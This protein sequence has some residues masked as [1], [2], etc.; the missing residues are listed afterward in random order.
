MEIRVESTVDD[1][2]LILLVTPVKKQLKPAMLVL[3]SGFLWNRRG[4]VKN[5]GDRL[6]AHGEK[7]SPCPTRIFL[8]RQPAY[9]LSST[10]RLPLQ[11]EKHWI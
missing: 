2:E 3:E 8:C 4:Y 10:L 5:H 9:V 6:T 1:D 11:P 7:D